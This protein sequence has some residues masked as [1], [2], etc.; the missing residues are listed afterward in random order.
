[1]SGKVIPERGLE[2]SGECGRK[3]EEGEWRWMFCKVQTQLRRRRQGRVPPK[4]H[5]KEPPDRP[6]MAVLTAAAE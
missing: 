5:P 6:A 2:S 4:T 1:M 3:T